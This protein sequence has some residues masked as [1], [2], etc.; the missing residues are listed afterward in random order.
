MADLAKLQAYL[1]G[2]EDALNK[3]MTG[4]Q[5]VEFD[6]SGTKIRYTPAQVPALQTYIAQ[7]KSQIAALGGGG[8]SRRVIY[9]YF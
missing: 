8:N 7:L 6:R 5:V 1:S 9:Q 2:A 4:T 3:L